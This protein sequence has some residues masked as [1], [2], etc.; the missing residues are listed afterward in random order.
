MCL[1]HSMTIPMQR[2]L[3][4]LAIGFLGVASL[5]PTVATAYEMRFALVIGNASYKAN[6][7]ATP[8]N[9]AALI[10]Q[11]LEGAGFQVAAERDLNGDSLR[12]AFSDFTDR[13]RKAGPD[14][15]AVVYFA[16]YGLQL[17][18]ENYLFPVDADM[19]APEDVPVRAMRLS[20][21]MRS[22]A[23]LHLKA[24]FLIVD[25]ARTNPSLLSGSPPAGGLA[26]VEPEPNMLIAFN[27]A[28]GTVARD[29]GDGYGAYAKALAEMVRDGG[30]TPPALFDRV[31]LRV[32]E[33]T[34][35]AQVPW[36]ASKIQAQ[37]VFFDRDPG[38]PAREDSPD[39]IAR[40]RAQP[41]RILGARDAYFVALLRDT[42]DGYA[43]FIADYWQDPMANRVQALLAARR[44]AITWRRSYQANVPDAYWTYLERYPQGPHAGDA[45]S[46][47][48][49]LGA[50]GALPSK[51]ARIEYDV[52]P[53]LPNELPY[54]ER[55][56]LKLDDP[57]FAFEPPPLLPAYFLGPPPA[58][59]SELSKPAASVGEHALSVP[60][61]APLPTH[62]RVP[63]GVAVP[64]NPLASDSLE[65]L[66]VRGTI[67]GPI[68]QNDKLATPSISQSDGTDDRKL[69]KAQPEAVTPLREETKAPSRSSEMPP[70]AQQPMTAQQPIDH[71]SS[72]LV[73]SPAP[74]M[75]DE[76]PIYTPMMGAPSTAGRLPPVQDK[77]QHTFGA[78]PLPTA[79]PATL[80]R[81]TNMPAR[82]SGAAQ[83][84]PQT[85]ADQL[86]PQ[87]TGSASPSGST[88]AT[89][90]RSPLNGQ[91]K[92][93]AHTVLA[94]PPKQF[95][96]QQQSVSAPQRPAVPPKVV[97]A[98]TDKPNV[99]PPSPGKP[100]T[101]LDGKQS[102]N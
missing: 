14:A 88:S 20:E 101:V 94:S 57:E 7:L 22:L 35:G 56:V 45:R 49:R 4:I 23:A 58:E 33:L 42:L 46:L 82:T 89:S 100:C 93:A 41:L 99:S 97:R 62:A 17:E 6:A 50:S 34:K 59:L 18:G 39:R 68:R 3:I 2:L 15:I 87:T 47:L 102:C 43:D 84:P 98:N 91:S 79:R 36:H 64:S 70:I 96:Q 21:Q 29:V 28:P 12:K 25:A 66:I 1:R 40:M 24:A 27:A 90:V 51:F 16:G 80:K 8:V 44:E 65:G 81:P 83:L 54:I 26:W 55:T 11:T 13:I 30:Q 95:G 9:D 5:S 31:R 10:A 75:A 32:N 63:P 19:V 37:F 72:S 61:F 86:P 73:Q 78:I 77:T 76:T 38:A 67:D 85:A 48:S 92:P 71:V 53:P 69:A 60:G 52:P 74:S